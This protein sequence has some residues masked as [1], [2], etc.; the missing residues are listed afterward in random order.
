[1]RAR[2]L[3]VAAALVTA[4]VLL[5]ASG[6]AAGSGSVVGPH[7][8]SSV[9]VVPGTSDYAPGLIRISFLLIDSQGAA[10]YRSGVRVSIAGPGKA[11]V[12]A[13]TTASL[14]PVGVPGSGDAPGDITKLYVAH[15]RAPR[16]GTYTVLVEAP[17]KTT[18]RGALKITVRAHPLAPAV[19]SKAIPSQTPTIASAHG[20]L[21]A[22]TTRTPPDTRLLDYSVAGSLAAHKP[23]VLVFATPKFCQSR[24]CGPVVDVVD[25][26]RRQF[27]GSGIRFIHVEVYKDNNPGLGYNKWV[28]Q[29]HLP[30]EPWTFLVGADGRIKARFE[31]SVSI[32]ELAASVRQHLS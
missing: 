23:F 15:L 31:G 12:F 2:G 14:E 4:A 25:A 13:S 11:R 21:T 30:S 19:G 32:K 22:L 29:W 26:V 7:R 27:T 6:G 24:T 28:K 18:L 17:G 5:V 9:T 16:A 20:N 8:M 10:P 3:A 1:V